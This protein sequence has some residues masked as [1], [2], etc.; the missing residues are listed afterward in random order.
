MTH[1]AII[2]LRVLLIFFVFNVAPFKATSKLF[3]NMFV[4]R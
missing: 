2:K 4:R 1:E 3:M